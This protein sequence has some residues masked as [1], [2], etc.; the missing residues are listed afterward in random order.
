MKKNLSSS[1]FPFLI[2]ILYFALRLIN[3]TKLPVFNDEA[4]YL[5]WG[6]KQIGS[7]NLLFASL[8]DGKQPL[9]IWLFGFAEKF[10]HDPLL[11]GRVIVVCFGCISLIALYLISRQFF[12]KKLSLIPPLMY[13]FIPLFS[14]YDRQALMEMPVAAISLVTLYFLLKLLKKYEVK[15]ALLIGLLLGTGFFIKSTFAVFAVTTIFL[16]LVTFF[17]KRNKKLLLSAGIV[18]IVMQVVLLPL[19]LKPEFWQTLSRNNQYVMG[20]SDIMKFPLSVW[21]ANIS[22]YFQIGFWILT[23]L[24]LLAFIVGLVLM[25]K[26]SYLSKIIAWWTILSLGIVMFLSKSPSSRYIVAFL[27]LVTVFSL[28]SFTKLY[29]KSKILS[30][31]LFSLLFLSIIVLTML[32]IVNPLQYFSTLSKVTACS[33]QSEYV[34]GWTSGYGVPEVV[35]NLN[36]KAQNGPVIVGVDLEVGN[37]QDAIMA[38][39]HNSSQVKGF[40][41]DQ[42]VIPVDLANYQCLKTSVPFYFVTRDNDT[43]GLE[44]FFDLE[45]KFYKPYG[46]EY[47]SLYKMKS[48]CIGSTLSLD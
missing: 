30:V 7:S 26:G 48:N 20:V 12:S 32:Q 6:W 8:K 42:R 1:V 28:Q 41:F 45:K 37:P 10:I 23:P 25:L 15:Y 33:D 2:L 4:I 46:K 34:T 18:F 13:I 3:L 40:Y 19:Y 29:S 36:A 39:F 24:V 17:I 9:L 22:A 16:L 31:S 5:D 43:S 44:K 47:I 27:P 35:N 14:F 11:A 38:Y 21:I